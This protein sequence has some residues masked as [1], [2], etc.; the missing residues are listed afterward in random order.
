MLHYAKK[1]HRK[2]FQIQTFLKGKY[3]LIQTF[4]KKKYFMI[5]TFSKE[6]Y[7]LIQTFSKEKYFLIQTFLKGTYFLLQTFLKGKYFLIQT[8]L[9]GKCSPPLENRPQAPARGGEL[10]LW[11]KCV[12]K[13]GSI[14]K[15][16]SKQKVN[17]PCAEK[18]VK[19]SKTKRLIRTTCAIRILPTMSS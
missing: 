12:G 8:F 2:Y 15:T 16:P 1:F 4:S 6:K 14:L 9:K 10:A 17:W 3:F 11:C 5:Q 19:S 7:F 13:K 18:N